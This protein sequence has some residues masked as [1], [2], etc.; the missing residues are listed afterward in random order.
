MKKVY[1][2]V[3]LVLVVFVVWCDSVEVLDQNGSDNLTS[4]QD[5]MTKVKE[6]SKVKINYVGKLQDGAVFDTSIEK[7]AKENDLYTS[8]RQYEPISFEVGRGQMIP[9]LEKGIIDVAEGESK[10]LTIEPSDAYGQVSEDKLRVLKVW[11][12]IFDQTGE[13][14]E[15]NDDHIKVDYNQPMAGKTLEFEVQLVENQAD[16]AKVSDGDT[17]QVNYVGRFENGEIF[18]TNMEE[19]AK[20]NDKYNPKKS[21]K[22]LKFQ[23]GQGQMIKG[24]D[25][26]VVGMEEWETKN[27]TLSPSEAYGEKDEN[28]IHNV[29]EW[30]MLSQ[31]GWKLKEIKSDSVVIDFNHPLAGKTLVF[32]VDV[33]D[34]T[35]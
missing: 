5:I 17:I 35:N 1:V 18:D 28:R 23:V 27:L 20:E 33:V 10:T 21:Y 12:Q 6:G 11:D 2:M 15:I 26:G 8:K 30:D 32:D 29:T 19:V 25:A 4:N 22:P 14:L 7:V 3:V 13:I 31:K 9:G 24:F 16:H 34:V